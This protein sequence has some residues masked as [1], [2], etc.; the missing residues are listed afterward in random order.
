M[1]KLLLASAAAV[2][3]CV[4]A[5]AADMP[6]KGPVYKAAPAPMFSWSGCYVG[7]QLGGGWGKKEWTDPGIGGVLF[8][9][10]HVDGFVG[11][12]G[13]GCDWQNG[14]WVFGLQADGNWADLKGHSIDS[15]SG[16]TITDHTRVDALGTATARI[17]Y[18]WD[19]SLFYG[20]GGYAW[21]HDKYHAIVNATGAE[22]YHASDTRSGWTLGVGYEVS[23]APNWSWKIEYNYMDFGRDRSNFVGGTFLGGVAPFDIQQT[24]QTVM[25]GVNYRFG[26]WGKGPVSAKY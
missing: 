23:F 9:S 8:S 26:G 11:G 17:G 22:F 18:A 20:K 24:V 19:R 6:T 10:H 16:G 1:K 5:M 25:V 12:G 21:A 7:A 2:A 4:P 15:L 3:L 13:I 14:Q